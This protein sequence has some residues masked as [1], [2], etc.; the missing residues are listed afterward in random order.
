VKTNPGIQIKTLIA[1][2]LQHFGYTVTYKKVWTVKQ[3]ALDIAFGSW[4]ESYNY[5]P[6]WMIVAQHFVPGTIVR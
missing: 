4:E 6:V 5:L 2:L 3:K 1:D